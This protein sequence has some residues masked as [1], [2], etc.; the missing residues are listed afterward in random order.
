[1]PELDPHLYPKVIR[2]MM[3]TAATCDRRHYDDFSVANN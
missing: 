1:M 2:E 3:R